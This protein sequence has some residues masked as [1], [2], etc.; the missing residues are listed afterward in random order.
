MKTKSTI[1][2]VAALLG[3][4][5]TAN[6]V[7]VTVTP[8][9]I[10]TDR[11]DF[12]LALATSTTENFE[13]TSYNSYLIDPDPYLSFDPPNGLTSL[14][15]DYFSLTADDRPTIKIW[16][17]EHED[18]HNTTVPE[19]PAAK[20]LYLDTD[21][22]EQGS[23]TDFLLKSPVTA[24]GFDYTGIFEPD[25]IEK[26]TESI[27]TVTIGSDIFVS[28]PFELSLNDDRLS[29]LFWG[30][31]GPDNFTTVTLIT[32]LDSGYGVDE[33]TFGSAIPLPPAIWLFGS[34]LL[35]LAGSGI[36]RRV[37]G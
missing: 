29:H 14:T 33:V 26:G 7:A 24:F 25:S 10:Y 20:F 13:S 28:D 9:T 17:D 22:G 35:A 34:G 2:L 37:S 21:I 27:F 19:P 5:V 31:I 16:N 6:A 11:G 3:L 12:E 30:V 32:S 1:L 8:Y 23:E 15:L 36:K 18:S 4:G